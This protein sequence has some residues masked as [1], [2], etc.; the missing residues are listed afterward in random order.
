MINNFYEWENH[1]RESVLNAGKGEEQEQDDE[2]QRENS[3]RQRWI[4]GVRSDGNA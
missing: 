2:R 4:F 3:R 1:R